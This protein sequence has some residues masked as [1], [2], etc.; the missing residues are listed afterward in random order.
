MTFD[1]IVAPSPNTRRG[2]LLALLLLHSACTSSPFSAPGRLSDGGRLLMDGLA[3]RMTADAAAQSRANAVPLLYEFAIRAGEPLNPAETELAAQQAA[4]S[5]VIRW[6]RV[7]EA[8]E[9]YIDEQCQDF[10]AALD[11]LER[12]KR[13]TLSGLN[14]LGSATVGIMGL[15]QAA[16]KSIGIVGVAFGLA[17]SLFE[18]SVSTV[19][20]E[21]PATSVSSVVQAQRDVL[22]IHEAAV[23]ANIDTQDRAMARLNAY[24]SY[25]SP[26][27]IEANIG[28][29][30]ASA[31]QANGRDI[32]AG[33][34]A[35]VT[36]TPV[37]TPPA[38]GSPPA[39]SAVPAP[40]V[41]AGDA[42]AARALFDWANTPGLTDAQFLDRQRR[43]EQEAH[44]EGF[45]DA[46]VAQLLN[47]GHQTTAQRA[48][49]ASVARKF[50]LSP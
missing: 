45:P 13:A 32:E 48:L 27:T 35:T 44:G 18:I 43:I 12:S 25:C 2:F 10:V 19:L 15:A 20:Y 21:L 31:R 38:L 29:L 39:A 50:G 30:L 47:P 1:W 46:T 6:G 41:G 14:V 36:Q 16:Q 24:V 11:R 8:G 3:A 26:V 33:T 49:A 5:G 28:K 40:D 4:L 34:Q 37:A 17:S 23:L 22:R 42:R 7:T 9:S